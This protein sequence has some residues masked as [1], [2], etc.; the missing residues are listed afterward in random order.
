MNRLYNILACF[1]FIFIISGI[2]PA[3]DGV[4]EKLPDGCVPVIDGTI[5]PV[6]AQVKKYHVNRNFRDEVPSLNLATWQATWNDTSIFIIVNVK[7]D[8]F[9]P[10][11]ESGDYQWMSDKVELY[12]DV[13]AELK[14]GGGPMDSDGHYQIAPWFYDGLYEYFMSGYW[15]SGQASDVYA[16]VAYRV[17]DP[18]YVYEYALNI[19][20]LRN[21]W[22][23]PLNPYDV[24]M[25]GFGVTVVDRDADGA[26][27]KR[28][29]WRN[30]GEID[31]SWAN[32][33]QCGTVSFSTEKIITVKKPGIRLKGEDILICIDSG[34][35]SYNWYYENQLLRDEIKQFCRIS[36]AFTGNYY[37]TIDNEYGCKTKS[38]PFYFSAKSGTLK[39]T[40]PVIEL[41]P[42]PNRGNFT[43]KMSGDQAGRILI[44]IRD[45]SGKIFKSLVFDK[46]AEPVSEEINLLDVPEG[47]YMLDI[48]FNNEVYLKRVLIN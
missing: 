4:L 40:Q 31:E 29:V 34:S 7:D 17:N 13:N 14:D 45:F 35:L 21:E 15:W 46:N 32:M 24:D 36:S 3:Q 37:V 48:L 33:D 25:I 11:W 23:A 1:C 26:D 19:Q 28:A 39:N 16:T 5:D 2:V 38:N 8:D 47:V 9:Y 20:D 43:L 30:T 6:W 22:G 12:F 18:D 42:V 44:N 41:Y 10:L 27:R